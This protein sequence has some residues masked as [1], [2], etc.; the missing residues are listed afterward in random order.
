[1]FTILRQA[2]LYAPEPV[3]RR[4]LLICAGKIIDIAPE[5]PSITDGFA[6][7]EVDLS[8]QR[9]IPG[10]VDC[11]VHITGGGGED[12]PA[13]RVPP[14]ALSKLTQ[15]G[16]TSCIGV[17]G[18]DGSTRTM[19]E[20][21]ATTL[22]LRAQ[23]IS[24]W[25]Y[26]GSYQYPPL[27]LTGS[28]RDDIVYVDPIIAVGELAISDHRSSQVT[29]D[30]FLRVVSDAYVAGMIAGKSGH[31]HLHLG[32]GPRGLDLIRRALDET[33]LPAR[34]FHPTHVNRLK[35]LFAEAQELSKRGVTVDVTAFPADEE[36][37]SAAEA[38]T[39]WI[40]AD[41]PV[42]QIT[43][44]SDGAGCLPVFDE[45]GR[46]VHMDIGQPLT[47]IETLRELLDQGFDL[48]QVLPIFTQNPARVAD[49]TQKG[50]LEVGLDA[51]LI[52][53]SPSAEITSVM[54]LGQWMVRDG[55]ITRLG[56]F[57]G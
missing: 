19:R 22:G 45:D 5:L 42:E 18:T 10:L 14:L 6:V 46:M 13:S 51:D 11:H 41:L 50:R 32:D 21:V 29:F 40:Q 43:C 44:S 56:S 23:G 26:T 24:A 39:R 55:H 25:C 3:G 36:S 49:L 4:D 31:T 57:E 9:V 8:G 48:E 12:G 47:L 38:I 52:V 30:E 54:A 17:L 37:Y 16:V 20:L 15:A 1:M 35:T 34:I 27:S 53:L 28:V 33:E 7:E 2:D